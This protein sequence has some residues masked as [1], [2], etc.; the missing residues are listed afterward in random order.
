M[1]TYS[2]TTNRSF[3]FLAHSGHYIRVNIVN[4]RNRNL[5]LPY[6]HVKLMLSFLQEP[7][8]LERLI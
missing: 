8:K 4:N 5:E 3:V 7:C 6:L 1:F 2:T